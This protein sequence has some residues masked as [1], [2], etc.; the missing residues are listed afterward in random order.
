MTDKTL[1][2]NY[3]EIAVQEIIGQLYDSYKKEGHSICGCLCCRNRVIA[4]A[5]NSLQPLY[6]TSEVEYALARAHFDKIPE[7]ARLIAAV[8]DSIR[9]VS[10][11]PVH[12]NIQL[13]KK[14]VYD[15][16]IA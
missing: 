7:R 15:F 3:S 9:E 8:M 2:I 12:E 6:V 13:L 16:A 1:V 4:L 14:N 11:N 10:L 5:L